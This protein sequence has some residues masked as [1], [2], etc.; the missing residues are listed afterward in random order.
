MKYKI[1]DMLI[2]DGDRLRDRAVVIIIG[3][4]FCKYTH[5]AWHVVDYIYYNLYGSTTSEIYKSDIDI[6]IMINSH[7][8][9]FI[10]A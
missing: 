6:N 4:Y 2:L 3:E 5:S 8:F 9:I 7:K 1:G 10:P